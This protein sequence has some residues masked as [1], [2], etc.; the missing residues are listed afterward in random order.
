MTGFK[1]CM[2]TSMFLMMLSPY[3]HIYI[4]QLRPN[5]WWIPHLLWVNKLTSFWKCTSDKFNNTNILLYN[6]WTCPVMICNVFWDKQNAIN[7]RFLDVDSMLMKHF[8]LCHYSLPTSISIRWQGFQTLPTVF[9]TPEYL[10]MGQVCLTN[11][12]CH[13]PEKS[14]DT[15][16]QICFQCVSCFYGIHSLEAWCLGTLSVASSISAATGYWKEFWLRRTN[17]YCPCICLSAASTRNSARQWS[18]MCGC[19]A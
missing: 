17:Y 16:W 4:W 5:I 14:K 6:A 15:R 7:L 9:T 11:S 1:L 18:S 8:W 12:M 2:T 19:I 13:F 10:I 3:E